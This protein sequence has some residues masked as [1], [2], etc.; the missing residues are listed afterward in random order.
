MAIDRHS[1]WYDE[2]VTARLASTSYVALL[3]G[4]AKDLGNPSLYLV[5]A[6]AWTGLFETSDRAPYEALFAMP[7]TLGLMHILFRGRRAE[8]PESASMV[9]PSRA[10]GPQEAVA[11]QD[12][13]GVHSAGMSL[14]WAAGEARVRD[15]TRQHP[16]KQNEVT[17]EVPTFAGCLV[18]LPDG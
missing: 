8:G 1:F 10:T 12:Y 17:S 7:A 11:V 6:R 15:A 4:Q 18:E 5:A 16:R 3:T 9:E 2:A 13:E 14:A